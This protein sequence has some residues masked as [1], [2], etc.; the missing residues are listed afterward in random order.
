MRLRATLEPTTT[1]SQAGAMDRAEAAERE[2]ERLRGQIK[3]LQI[4]SAAA[5]ASAALSAPAPAAAAA[6]AAAAG[7][8]PAQRD[9]AEVLALSVSGREVW[10]LRSTLLLQRSSLLFEMFAP[11]AARPPP[12]DA[13]GRPF[14]WVA[15]R[16][17]AL[18]GACGRGAGVGGVRSVHEPGMPHSGRKG[19]KRQTGHVGGGT[20]GSAWRR[21][22]L[23]VQRGLPPCAC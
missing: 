13:L 3:E 15:A 20:H 5:A 18:A 8:R 4:S 17:G 7:G 19:L 2:I 21:K 1:N 9:D 12:R 11:E 10:A 23:R 22:A 14:L 16:R 6:A